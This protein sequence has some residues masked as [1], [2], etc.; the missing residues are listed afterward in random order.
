[1]QRNRFKKTLTS[2]VAELVENGITLEQA[3]REFERQFLIASIQ[4][5]EGNLGRSALSLGVHR[6]TLRN[7][8]ARLGITA[9]D[10]AGKSSR[11]ST[12]R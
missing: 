9:K 8:L 1:M 3:S 10:Y 5:N 6:N 12:S 11:T 4:V 2:L 7:K